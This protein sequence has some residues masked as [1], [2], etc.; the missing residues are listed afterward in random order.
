MQVALTRQVSSSASSASTGRASDGEGV[1]D[2]KHFVGEKN[3]RETQ[4]KRYYSSE[5][6]VWAD[7]YKISKRGLVQILPTYQAG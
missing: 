5:K 4:L 6:S 2:G 3:N 7:M 1:E